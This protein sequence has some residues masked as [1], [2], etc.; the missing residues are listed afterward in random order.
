MSHVPSGGPECPLLRAVSASGVSQ[1]I[2]G[3]RAAGDD[4]AE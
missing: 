1:R 3:V 2:G 4:G